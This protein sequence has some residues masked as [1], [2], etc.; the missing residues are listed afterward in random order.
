M[1]YSDYRRIAREKLSNNWW[2]SIGVAAVAW[3]L[4]G[5]LLGGSFLPE[6][7]YKVD[8]EELSLINI[9][10]STVRFALSA[11]SA[12]GL[13]Q[14]ILGGTIQMGYAKYLLAQH[15]GGERNFN[16]LFSQFNNFGTGFAQKFLRSLY[17]FLWGLLFIIPGIIASYRYA[18]TPYIL[19]ENPEMTA[20]Q[21][22]EQSKYMMDGHKGEL[23][24]L[25]L[26]FIGWDIL[27]ALT[28]NLGNLALNPYKNAAEA[29]FYR[30]LQDQLRRQHNAGYM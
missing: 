5:L 23:F 1:S 30:D 18:M 19:A 28:L 16:D 10:N 8:Q 25:H 4:G 13:A 26:T 14:F 24:C 3:L 6:V 11:G 20:S 15:D 29:V 17:S 9:A 12:L 22:I 7:N 21:A 2:L 27:A